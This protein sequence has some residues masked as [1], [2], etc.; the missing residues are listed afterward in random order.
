[1]ELGKLSPHETGA[2]RASLIR[3][4]TAE[5]L[6]GR[7][8]YQTIVNICVQHGYDPPSRFAVSR[9]RKT[10]PKGPKHPERLSYHELW[11]IFLAAYKR[12]IRRGVFITEAMKEVIVAVE[13]LRSVDEGRE[14]RKTYKRKQKRQKEAAKKR[15]AKPRDTQHAKT[16]RTT[17]GHAS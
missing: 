17:E 1:M 12:G 7:E 15:A 13:Y 8:H 3:K 5:G 4:L 14:Q 16:Q 6:S 9:A 10:V 2:S 11:D